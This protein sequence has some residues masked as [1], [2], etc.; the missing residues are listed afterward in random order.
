[1]EELWADLLTDRD[2]QMQAGYIAACLVALLVAFGGPL[3]RAVAGRR[4]KDPANK[5]KPAASTHALTE[6]GS[7]AQTWI[8]GAGLGALLHLLVF[9]GTAMAALIGW[10]IPAEIERLYGDGAGFGLIFPNVTMPMIGRLAQVVGAL[11]FALI[12]LRLLRLM[13]PLMAVVAATLLAIF[14]FQYV[15]GMPVGLLPLLG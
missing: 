11:T 7:H 12:A 1:M 5:D 3:W 4:R 6:A 14:A 2:D 10:R 13:I 9:A 8:E 15:A